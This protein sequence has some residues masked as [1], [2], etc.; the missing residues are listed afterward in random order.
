MRKSFCL[1]G[2]EAHEKEKRKG[3]E[4]K[5]KT[6]GALLFLGATECK[7]ILGNVNGGGWLE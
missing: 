6:D 3:G 1:A 5:G 4:K 2:D 7:S